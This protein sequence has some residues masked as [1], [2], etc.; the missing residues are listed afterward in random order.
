MEVLVSTVGQ[1]F[2]KEGE[3][4]TDSKGINKAV[5]SER[6]INYVENRESNKSLLELTSNYSTVAGNIRLLYKCL[7]FL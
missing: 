4:H 1:K 5:F 3:I 6:M 2:H 7:A